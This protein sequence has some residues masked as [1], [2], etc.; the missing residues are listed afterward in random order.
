MGT[1]LEMGIF[2][3]V[4][5]DT[6]GLLDQCPSLTEAT[7]SFNI[8]LSPDACPLLAVCNPVEWLGKGIRIKEQIL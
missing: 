2:F 7:P 8:V 1:F 5:A 3:E 6:Q 4:A